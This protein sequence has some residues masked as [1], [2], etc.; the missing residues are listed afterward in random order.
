MIVV[1]KSNKYYIFLRLYVCVRARA[2][3]RV[4]PCVFV[5]VGARARPCTFARVILLIQ[6]APRMR[7]IVCGLSG[8]ATFFDIMS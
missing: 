4:G 3:A 2:R 8:F 1:C 5:G 7:H 6:H